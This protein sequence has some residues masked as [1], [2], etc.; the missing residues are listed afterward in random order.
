MEFNWYVLTGITILSKKRS[1]PVAR[2]WPHSPG[3]PN[4]IFDTAAFWGHA[5]SCCGS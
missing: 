5:F 2:M 3:I 1:C 4:T